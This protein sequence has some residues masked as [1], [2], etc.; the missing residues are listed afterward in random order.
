MILAHGEQS[1]EVHCLL[2]EISTEVVFGFVRRI[3]QGNMQEQW[4][5]V[6]HCYPSRQLTPVE[7]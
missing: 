2:N 7:S 5:G 6:A 3:V 1:K 4:I